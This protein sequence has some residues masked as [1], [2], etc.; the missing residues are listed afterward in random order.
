MTSSERGSLSE[1]LAHLERQDAV[2]AERAFRAALSV[3]ENRAPVLQGL[4]KS[5]YDQRRFA[6][7]E[8]VF[9][10]AEA[11]DPVP[12]LARYHVGMCRLV[13]G[14][15][16][17]GW[18]LW[19]ERLRVP[20]FRHPEL[21]LPRWQGEP[22]VGKRL[23]V[24]A[25]QGYGDAIQFLRFL[26]RVVEESGGAVTFGCS[27]PLQRLLSALAAHHD[28]Q[29]A[30]GQVY[31]TD[32]DCYA[33]VC[34]LAG[35]FRIGPADL[36]GEIPYLGCDPDSIDLWRARLPAGR[37]RIGLCWAGRPGH[38]QDNARSIP[39]GMFAS[40]AE[41][42]GIALVGLQRSMAEA[43]T[44]SFPDKSPGFL[45]ADWSAEIGDFADTAAMIT[46]L[47][48]VITV[49]T[50]IAHLAGALGRPA[51]VLLPFAPDWRWL[52]DRDDSP[53]Y[54]SLRLFR[55][56][57]PADWPSVIERVVIVLAES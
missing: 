57:R 6:E 50:A 22:L 37:L 54:P 1:G 17:G 18:P 43:K 23:L 27:E 46:A 29:L 45:A 3:N 53:W 26:P 21:P 40:L 15:F 56:N 5:L 13:Q 30:S 35:L 11:I 36:P 16:A 4:G 38:P 7:A 14:D 33:S 42:P 20:V 24:L 49:D 51:W 55:Q 12:A 48:L 19:E 25:E 34:S 32:F 47:D 52:L 9:R 28:F 31:P 44:E 8:A 39:P 10:E 2:A 41:I